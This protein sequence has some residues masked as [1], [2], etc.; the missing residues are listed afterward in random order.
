[1]HGETGLDGSELP[2]PA[3]VPETATAV[4]AMIEHSHEEPLT[5]VAVGPLTNVAAALDADPGL[6]ARLA[7]IVIMGGSTAVG[8]VTP[9]AEFNIWCDPEAAAVTFAAGVPMRMAGLDLTRQTACDRATIERL[10]S[11]GTVAGPV[12]GRLLDFYGSRVHAM[13]GTDPVIHDACA[14]AWLIQP[15]LI[16]AR[17]TT[18][19]VATEGVT[20]G[21]TVCDLRPGA[22][23]GTTEVGMTIDPVGFV[24]LLSDALASHS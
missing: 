20:R 9:V 15:D 23:R 24:D 4:E 17:R 2:P 12:A 14:V 3:G 5:I 10:R 8:N 1:V 22:D 18:V 13:T 7:E 21:M 19:Q 6:A 16:E 11:S